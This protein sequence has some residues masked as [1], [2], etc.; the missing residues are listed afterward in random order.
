MKQMIKRETLR[1]GSSQEHQWG[2][3]IEDWKFSTIVTENRPK[4]T[5]ESLLWQ[6]VLQKP[7]SDSANR[8]WDGGPDRL[9]PAVTDYTQIHASR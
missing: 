5:W 3:L 6:A 9:D 4:S 1:V 8:P 7:I 2:K